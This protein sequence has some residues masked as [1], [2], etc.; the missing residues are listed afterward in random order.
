MMENIMRKSKHHHQMDCLILARPKQL[1]KLFTKV[2]GNTKV[3]SS[4][5]SNCF[6]V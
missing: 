2:K 4:K 6:F 1:F 5:Y 3:E